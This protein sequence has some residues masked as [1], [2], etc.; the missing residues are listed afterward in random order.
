MTNIEINKFCES[1]KKNYNN[2]C[3]EITRGVIDDNVFKSYL[4]NSIVKYIFLNKEYESLSSDTSVTEIHKFKAKYRGNTYIRFPLAA[5]KHED[6]K[7]INGFREAESNDL[8]DGFAVVS[9]HDIRE[10]Y[11]HLRYASKNERVVFGIQ[12]CKKCLKEYN[13]VLSGDVFKLV[14]TEE[15]NND[16]LYNNIVIGTDTLSDIISKNISSCKK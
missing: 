4:R 14:I 2:Y 15:G 11:C 16:I 6:D 10:H 1:T 3:V 7:Y 13:D 8:A 5:V 9:K 12:L